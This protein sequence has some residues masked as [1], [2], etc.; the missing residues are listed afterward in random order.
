M[1]LSLFLI[2]AIANAQSVAIPGPGLSTSQFSNGYSYCKVVTATAAMVSGSSDLTTYPL[3]VIL[4]T[5]ASNNVADLKTV[6][7][8]GLVNNSS[9]YDIGFYSSTT[10]STTPGSKLN[11]E[12]ESYDPASGDLI[13]HVNVTAVHTGGGTLISMYYGGAYSSFQSTAS[14]VWNSN[15]KAVWHLATTAESTSGGYTLT[16]V[17]APT[18]TT[19]QVDGA[20]NFVSAS[21]QYMTNANAPVSAYPI[22]LE[23]WFRLSSATFASNEF[24]VF[25][26]IDKPATNDDLF[27]D[28]FYDAGTFQCLRAVSQD[29][30]GGLRLIEVAFTFD[31]N[32]HHI[33]GVFTNAT[34]QTVYLDGVAITPTTTTGAGATPGTMTT[35]DIGVIRFA[36]PTV[37]GYQK[38]D[39]DEVRISD[40]GRSADWILTEYRNQ[41]APGTYISAGARVTP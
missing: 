17:N 2:S 38:G 29:A 41:S 23:S 11:W 1:R 9:G 24:R 39:L 31:T 33:A 20:Y 13:A 36:G 28:A 37:G 32:W 35:S 21:S 19:G 34:T 3:S 10:C 5:A 40:I 12:V 27:I 30:G 7:N 8:G 4:T 14:A 6:A 22:T 25:V 16:P 18:T 15:Y 26:S